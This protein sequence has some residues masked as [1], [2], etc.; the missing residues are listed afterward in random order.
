MVKKDYYTLKIDPY[1][2]NLVFPLR[3]QEYLTLEKSIID[4]G[5]TEPIVTWGD[6]ILDGHNRYRICRDH[7]IPF[8]ITNKEF[9]KREQAVVWICRQQLKRKNL[10][11][12][13][14]KYLIGSQYEAEISANAAAIIQEHGGSSHRSAENSFDMPY[15]DETNSSH[16]STSMHAIARQIGSEHHIAWNTVRKYRLYMKALEEIRSKTP[17]VV[18]LILSG[19]Y[20]IS[21]KNIIRLSSLNPKQIEDVIGRLNQQQQS[22]VRY[23]NSRMEIQGFMN[24]IGNNPLEPRTTVKDMPPFDPDAEIIALTLTIP[25]WIGSV[26]RIKKGKDLCAITQRARNQLSSALY[27]LQKSL[28]GLIDT[29]KEVD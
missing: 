2:R 21:H 27:D 6:V 5:C 18:P 13:T 23:K 25:S 24:Q 7:H 26:E 14:R 4:S 10:T 19:Q 12:E 29:L 15:I 1:F 8:A 16:I 9:Q 20:K 3:K 17:S 22:F 11:Y 28:S